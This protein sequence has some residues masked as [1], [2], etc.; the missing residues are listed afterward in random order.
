[1]G[2]FCF[3]I[4]SGMKAVFLFFC[5]VIAVVLAQQP[6][7]QDTLVID[8]FTTVTPQI[9]IQTAL[10]SQYPIVQTRSTVASD[11]LGGERD[12][13]LTVFSGTDNL[14]L[15]SGVS[16]GL[17]QCATPA[18]AR[19]QSTVQYDGA[20]GSI[21][22]NPSGLGG[23][24]LRN[25]GGNSFRVSVTSDLATRVDFVV[26][27][28]SANARCVFN[29]TLVA[30]STV[31]T[32]LLFSQFS[33][34]CDFS[35]VGAIEIIALM[36]PNVD[37]Q[38]SLFSVYGPIP[39]T[40]TPTPSPSRI[41]SQ[42]GTPSR[43]PT[44]SDRCVC[45]CNA[46]TCDIRVD[47]LH[48]FDTFSYYRTSDFDDIDS[49]TIPT[50]TVPTVTVP[51]FTIPSVTIPTVTFGTGDA[52]NVESGAGDASNVESGAGVVVMSLATLMAVALAF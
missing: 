17:F 36:E 18:G 23:V 15:S 42:S 2:V 38:V 22:L 1:M 37:V 45:N 32:V 51:T 9:I 44:P 8:D 5:M 34:G 39:A 33:S 6:G 10:D 47:P 35:S 25:N 46:F 52:S 40:P 49:I 43:T 4:L 13:R 12:L 31:D 21:N 11:V 41:P 16:N 28:G 24:N 26:Y 20:D 50:V 29:L 48:R 27:S 30:G 3:S 19:G 7:F 14:V